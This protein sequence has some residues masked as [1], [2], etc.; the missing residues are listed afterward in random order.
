MG[1]RWRAR[2]WRLAPR[3]RMAGTDPAMAWAAARVSDRAARD[4]RLE[5][6]RSVA[7]ATDRSV[8]L[9][10][11][12]ADAERDQECVRAWGR[13]TGLGVAA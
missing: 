8:A 13:G 2:H 12:R 9:A 1:L 7:L 3:W 11:D 6:D 4:V 10:T 5:P